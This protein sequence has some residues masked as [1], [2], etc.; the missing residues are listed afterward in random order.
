MQFN[1]AEVFGVC[2]YLIVKLGEVVVA[3]Q[4]AA[5]LWRTLA[6]RGEH[7]HLHL[8]ELQGHASL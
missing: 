6:L 2:R 7:L 8:V 3:T 5:Y 4:D 1:G